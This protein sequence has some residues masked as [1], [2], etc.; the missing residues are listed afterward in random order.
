[1]PCQAAKGG[2]RNPLASMSAFVGAAE[3]A[4]LAEDG[5][6]IIDGPVV[7]P[8]DPHEVRGLLDP[9]FARFD[10]FP[11]TFAHDLGASR[12][13]RSTA[14]AELEYVT[15]MAPALKRTKV[16]TA[17]RDVARDLMGARVQLTFDH[18]I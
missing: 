1:P 12:A 9:L 17:F 10:D 7:R 16:F 8:T 13:A 15:S 4:R 5:F 14:I 18:A 2:I 6:V 3:R 11:D